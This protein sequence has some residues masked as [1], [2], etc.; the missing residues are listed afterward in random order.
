[1]IPN[2]NIDPQFQTL[3]DAI[4]KAKHLA[5]IS[6][7]AQTVVAEISG[8]T[9]GFYVLLTGSYAE[10]REKKLTDHMAPVA[11]VLPNGTIEIY[12]KDFAR[13]EHV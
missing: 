8:H 10:L 12:V 13:Y 11:S 7:A 3:D 4:A 2:P 1:M 5:E 9:V 6:N